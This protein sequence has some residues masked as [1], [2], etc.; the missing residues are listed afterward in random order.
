MAVDM[1]FLVADQDYY[2]SME[3]V[4]PGSRYVV[5]P[6]PDG[7]RGRETGTWTHWAPEAATL[8]DTGW[9]VHVSSSLAN[10]QAVLAVV[11]AVCAESGVPFKHLTGRR[12]FLLLHN[13][14][15]ARVQAGKFCALYPP[16]Q[17]CARLMLERLS[18]ELSGISGPYVLTDR[19]FG[20]SECVSYRYG[21]FRQQWRVNA[22]GYPVHTMTGPDG[23]Q[24]DDKREPRF[25]LPPGLS[26]PFRD[27]K[28][29]AARGPVI[30]RGYTYE[31]V[32]QHS[33][34]G[35]AYQ[36]RSA[37]DEQVFVKE[38]RA[39]NG[40]TEDGA[41]AKSRLQAE[42]LT[43]RAI[44]LHSPGLCP[45]PM[46]FFQH[47]EQSYLVTEWVAG[48]SL[49]HWMLRNNPVL[50]IAPTPAEFAE[51]YRR[52]LALL[53]NLAGQF[54]RLHELGFVFLDLSPNNILVDDNDVPRLIDF[55]AAQPISAVQ[56]LLGTPG[57]QHPDPKTVAEQDPCELDR[58]GLAA[59]ALLL[60]FNVH[61]T[62][63]RHPPALE[64]LYADLTE[65][66]PVPPRLWRWA[67]SYH[68]SDRDS[69][70]PTPK[71]VRDDTVAAL[72]QLAEQTADALMA[73]AQPDHPDR[74]Y[75]TIPLGYQTNTRAL[76][77]GTAGVLH[78]LHLTGRACDPAVIRRLRDETLAAA[79]TSV[80]GMLFGSAG[81][82]CVLA[83]LGELDAAE[84]L[85]TA[86]AAHPLNRTSATLG[87][88]AAGTALGLLIQHQRTGEQRWLE[89]ADQLLR[90]LP[91]DEAE[92][93]A[94]LGPSQPAG[95]VGGRPGVALG[96]YY[97]YRR[98][99][100]PRLFTRGMRMLRDELAYAEPRAADGLQFKASHTDRRIFPYLF[101]GSAGYATVLSRYLAHRPD[102]T[103]GAGADFEAGDA[104][105]RCLR[106]C[107]IR[108]TALPGLFSG[109]AGLAVTLAAA[110]RRL[111]RPELLDAAYTSARGLF[112]HA[113]P[114]Q[115]G[116]RWLGEP[117]PRL[118]ADLWSGSAGILLAIHQLTDPTPGLLGLL[119]ENTPERAPVTA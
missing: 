14:H 85:L 71:A 77:A 58:F 11:S 92:L 17:D 6:M 30:L 50:R 75:P 108:F 31:K 15:G 104:L 118:S 62:V 79:E 41:D 66:A 28:A 57:Y 69:V 101:A 64:H 95:L 53:D 110:G 52:G 33:N 18:A 114:H 3:A 45:R 59:L 19:R 9:K 73:M 91:E 99:D 105:D 56:R 68:S 39:H 54:R 61:E 80:P 40:Y 1:S 74:V 115:A 116:V 89:L 21:A 36:F 113:I 63:E 32:L 55:E 22:E 7:W 87:S 13:K 46:E 94:Q 72:R 82:A 5:G 100:D 70:L 29:P 102:A 106:S 49:Y 37:A 35:G 84:T 43:L 83:E 96:L 10:A 16:T 107:T 81:I 88:G 38:A 111:G 65:L 112:R 103:F 98:T 26:D 90:R 27:D 20:D 67:T 117:G 51:Y 86:A 4:D 109:Q 119:D 48:G 25:V 78:A 42:Y 2:A 76:A 23:Q 8:P 97:L 24:I 60:F 34:A 93:T 12:T 44:H 47:W